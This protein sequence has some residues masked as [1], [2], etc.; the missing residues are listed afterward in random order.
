MREVLQGMGLS[1]N[2]ECTAELQGYIKRMVSEKELFGRPM[3]LRQAIL[4]V[5]HQFGQDWS[6]LSTWRGPPTLWLVVAI[7]HCIQRIMSGGNL[8]QFVDR[9]PFPGN[10]GRPGPGNGGGPPSS[11]PSPPPRLPLPPPPPPP[12]SGS[13]FCR[14]RG[15]QP[16]TRR[17]DRGDSPIPVP[18]P[19]PGPG[20]P[21]FPPPGGAAQAN[22]T[23]RGSASNRPQPG[24]APRRSRSRARDPPTPPA[25]EPAARNRPGSPPPPPRQSRRR[26]AS[27]QAPG[28]RQDDTTQ[29][30]RNPPKTSST[31]SQNTSPVSPVSSNAI[32]RPVSAMS[33]ARAEE[34]RSTRR[35]SSASAPTVRPRSAA[36]GSSR[37]ELPSGHR[38]DEGPAERSPGPSASRERT[39]LLRHQSR[40][41]PPSGRSAERPPAA[42]D[43]RQY[44]DWPLWSATTRPPGGSERRPES[45]AESQ[46]QRH[47]EPEPQPRSSFSEAMN[48]IRAAIAE[49]ICRHRS[50]DRLR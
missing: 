19:V 38:R 50:D 24:S 11:P 41:R 26:S 43:N 39:S 3:C 2:L 36:A 12:L 5:L 10:D 48:D 21:P 33:N 16:D 37:G 32:P 45:R 1:R 4:S 25:S 18:V 20:G 13:P 23:R 14:M 42:M 9:G 46:Q 29:P 22:D 31:S 15:R 28:E 35:S 47:A 49:L 30:R 40:Q 8:T 27:V 6:E 7:E 34:R 44:Y 17:G